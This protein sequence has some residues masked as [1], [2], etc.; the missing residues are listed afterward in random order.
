MVSS[1]DLHELEVCL[2]P[3][4]FST[5]CISYVFSFGLNLFEDESASVVGDASVAKTR[6]YHHSG[7][8]PDNSV[9]GLLVARHPKMASCD[10]LHRQRVDKKERR[11]Q[12]FIYRQCFQDQSRALS[13]HSLTQDHGWRHFDNCGG[14][15]APREFS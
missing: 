2:L 12:S 7:L 13:G 15:S 8:S 3:N 1:S 6:T 9:G 11:T 4:C 5:E 10:E 14:S